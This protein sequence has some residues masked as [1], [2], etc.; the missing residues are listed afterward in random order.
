M[1][2][3]RGIDKDVVYMDNGILFSHKN[4]WNIDT[5][6]NMDGSRYYHNQWS[7]SEKDK[8]HTV[9][10]TCGIENTAQM[11]LCTKQK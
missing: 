9:S 4:E 5:C 3:N 11:N 10:L 6:S 2:I 1:F 8:Y 7:K